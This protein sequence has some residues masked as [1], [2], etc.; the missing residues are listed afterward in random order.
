MAIWK[1]SCAF[2]TETGL[3]RDTVVM[4]PVFD[5]TSGVDDPDGLCEDLATALNTWLTPSFATQITVK[6][7]DVEKKPHGPAAGVAT[8][9]PGVYKAAA[10]PRE[11]SLCLSF[12]SEY[13]V[14]R[15]RGRLYMPAFLLGAGAVGVRP[16]A[17]IQTKGAELAQ[18]LQ[19]IGSIDVDWSIWSP[20]DKVA[21]RVTHW[22]V[23]DEW[24]IQR[25]RGMRPT[26]RASGIT[27]E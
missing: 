25:S 6:A 20:T 21:R 23:D 11:I 26:S 4:N 8:R 19:D 13:N 7:Y 17:A 14:K 22:F 12:Y 16:L 18:I 9:N 10:V 3:S 15:Q 27:S 24:D 2:A 1:C 5:V